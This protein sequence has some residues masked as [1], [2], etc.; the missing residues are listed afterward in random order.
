VACSPGGD[1]D[2]RQPKPLAYGSLGVLAKIFGLRGT[3]DGGRPRLEE[4][5]GKQA[6]LRAKWWR[7]NSKDKLPDELFMPILDW[8]EKQRAE[9]LR[10]KRQ[11]HWEH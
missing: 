1:G 3:G 7:G 5:L 4:F 8:V 10:V 2:G 6:R 11:E 9:E